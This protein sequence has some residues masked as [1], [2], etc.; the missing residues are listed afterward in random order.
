MTRSRMFLGMTTGLLAV[1]GAVAVKA[2]NF[3]SSI[4]YYVTTGV[5]KTCLQRTTTCQFNSSA[6]LTCKTAGTVGKYFT[7]KTVGGRCNTA[8]ILKYSQQ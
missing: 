6:T 5:N 8:R 1:A 3:G 7:S 2:S 4:G